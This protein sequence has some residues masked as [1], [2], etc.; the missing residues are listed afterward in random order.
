[1]REPVAYLNGQWLAAGQLALPVTDAGFVLGVTIAEQLRTFRGRLF[2]LDL[3]L[4]RFRHSL[5]IIG[6]DPGLSIDEFGR[7]AEELAT[8]NHKLL[9]PDDDLG[10]TM[11]V[12]PGAYA[13]YSPVIDRPTIALH[14]YELPFRLWVQQYER[15]QALRVTSVRQVPSEC[16]PPSLKCRSRMHYYLADREAREHDPQSRA[17]LLGIDGQVTESSSANLLVWRE[18]EGLVSPPEDRILPGVSLAVL[19]EIAQSMKIP[20]H[21]RP[22]TVEDVQSADEAYLT[23]TSPCMLPVSRCNGQ[24]IGGGAPGPLFNKLLDAWSQLVKVDIRAQARQ[25]AARG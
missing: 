8:R 17:L 1:M 24:P 21:S 13:T 18:S 15:G 25:F 2:R 16:W 23:S 22:L 9:Q 10:L 19:R 11:F 7:L 14:T 4:A 3:H 6:V 12:T 20:F 5:E